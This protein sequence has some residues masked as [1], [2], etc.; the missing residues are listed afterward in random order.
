[1]LPMVFQR[2]GCPSSPCTGLGWGLELRLELGIVLESSLCLW[3]PGWMWPAPGCFGIA[4]AW[5][6]VRE[7]GEWGLA[8]S[9]ALSNYFVFILS[10]SCLRIGLYQPLSLFWNSLPLFS[11]D[12]FLPTFLQTFIWAFFVS[13]TLVSEIP[14]TK[15]ITAKHLY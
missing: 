5:V 3:C 1:M 14:R 6:G 12:S 9:S 11:S 2:N 7:V 10:V 8:Q 15:S 13:S 4:G